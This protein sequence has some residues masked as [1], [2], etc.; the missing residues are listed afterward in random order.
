M[1]RARECVLD[2]VMCDK[3]SV[4]LKDRTVSSPVITYNS[5]CFAVEKKYLYVV[6]SSPRQHA[7]G[8]HDEG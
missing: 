7:L 8:S 1:D 2:R 3:M 6:N 5:E 4:K